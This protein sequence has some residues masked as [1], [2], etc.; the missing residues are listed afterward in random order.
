MNPVVG[1]GIV[2]RIPGN[3]LKSLFVQIFVKGDVIL[4]LEFNRES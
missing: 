4:I 1:V 2:S 3:N